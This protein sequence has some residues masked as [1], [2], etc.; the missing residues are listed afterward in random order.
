VHIDADTHALRWR[1]PGWFDAAGRW[2]ALLVLSAALLV[3]MSSFAG[4]GNGLRL[5]EQASIP[6]RDHHRCTVPGVGGWSRCSGSAVRVT[7][8]TRGPSASAPATYDCG[9]PDAWPRTAPGLP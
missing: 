6:A 8:C 9:A 1:S 3:G 7:G 5:V 2:V 4:V